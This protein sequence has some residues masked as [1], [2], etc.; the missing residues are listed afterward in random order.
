M[1]RRHY[2]EHLS[3]L[4]LHQEHDVAK[5]ASDLILLKNSFSTITASIFE[6][7]KIIRNLKK[8][9][10]YLLSTSFS[11][12]ILVA[13]GLLATAAL[14]IHPI[15][16]LWANII[17]EAFMAFA[18]AFEKGEPSS[19]KYNQKSDPKGNI[20][21]K[22]IKHSII[23]IAAMTGFYF[24]SASTYFLHKF[25]YSLRQNKYKP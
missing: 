18:F 8:I 13:G 12:A 22:D 14:P 1:T 4:Q 17:E 7:K 6:G 20:I 11:E 15:Q 19:A 23:I 16:I 2:I 9:L 25:Y 21:S 5:E 10:I 3:A 24:C